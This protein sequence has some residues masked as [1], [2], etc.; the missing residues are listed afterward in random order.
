MNHRDELNPFEVSTHGTFARE[1]R[2][3]YSWRD[4]ASREIRFY[5]RDYGVDLGSVKE[6]LLNRAARDEM[7]RLIKEACREP[8]SLEILYYAQIGGPHVRGEA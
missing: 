1:G 4:P 3:I 6:S 2:T 8:T 5:D 7:E